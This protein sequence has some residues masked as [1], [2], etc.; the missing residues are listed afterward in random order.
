MS[1]HVM[2]TEIFGVDFAAS[3]IREIFEEKSVVE[4]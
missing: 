1:I 2:D 4:N 3:E